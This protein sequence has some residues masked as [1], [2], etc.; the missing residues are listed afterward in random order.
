MEHHE[1]AVELEKHRRIDHAKFEKLNEKIETLGH[2]LHEAGHT[3]ESKMSE[4]RNVFEPGFG[5]GGG[6]AMGSAGGGL[7]G[8]AIGGF[9]GAALG[10]GGFGFGNNRN[11]GYGGG[12]YVTPMQL[13]TATGSIIDANQNTTLLQAVG[14][15][16]ASIPVAAQGTQLYVANAMSDLRSH[17]GQVENSLT[18]GQM[19]INKNVSDAIA[20]SLASQN[21]I[22]V[23]VLQSAAATREA[24]NANG[25]ANLI[26]TKDSQFALAAAIVA[27]GEKTRAMLVA[28]NEA[29]LRTEITALQIRLQD[30]Q[31]Q[32]LARGTE[33][34]VTQTVNQNQAQAQAQLQAQRQEIVLGNI[35]SRLD[36]M[37][38]AIA[39]NSN[40]II[41]NTGAVATG[42][43]TANPVN[44]RT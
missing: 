7:G 44:V 12:D 8:G 4:V 3:G 11:G 29:A 17:L 2:K 1:L 14:E 9:L 21:N 16:K 33:V 25:T 26:A 10:N 31:A 20:S 32:S 37:Q 23:N 6:G 5:Y 34:N 38:Q 35:W 24:V 28:Q 36:G 40:M 19:A 13:Q 22:N 15:T 42:P 43:N 41:G 18:A 27:D 30:Q 39:T